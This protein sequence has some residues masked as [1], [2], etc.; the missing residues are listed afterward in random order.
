VHKL[1]TIGVAVCLLLLAAPIPSMA[2]HDAAT[3]AGHEQPAGDT[4]TAPHEGPAVEHG[5]SEHAESP[6]AMVWRFGNFALLVALL[7][8]FLKAP[9]TTYLDTRSQQIRTELVEAERTRTDAS[10][11]LA[12]L[13]ARMKALPQELAALRARGT[14]EIAAEEARIREQAAAERERLLEQTRRE[15]DT[16]LRAARRELAEY[17][18]ELSVGVARERLKAT[19]TSED[20]VRL[21]D[22]YVSTVGKSHE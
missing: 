7:W 17:A 21:V 4:T 2:Q 10:A 5:E 19:M 3:P 22:R 20:H 9:L 13:E 14:E 18:A 1:T 16:R 8:Y 15:I 11:R 12:E 6:L